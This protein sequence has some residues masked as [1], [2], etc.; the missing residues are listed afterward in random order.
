MKLQ[1]LKSTLALSSI[2]ER[3]DE[4][5]ETFVKKAEGVEK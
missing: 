2:I 5:M 1:Q 4:I 3:T